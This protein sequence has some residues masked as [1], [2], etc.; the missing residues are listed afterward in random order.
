MSNFN[1]TLDSDH[2]NMLSSDEF[3][4]SCLNTRT[5]KSFDI[6][7]TDAFILITEEGLP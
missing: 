7:K 4:V 6:I 5:T 3:G 2:L 1:D